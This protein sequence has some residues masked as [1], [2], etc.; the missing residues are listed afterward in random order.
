MAV[1]RGVEQRVGNG[2]QGSG[3]RVV[4]HGWREQ[5]VKGLRLHNVAPCTSWCLTS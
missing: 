3:R 5:A 2:R 1:E 4:Q